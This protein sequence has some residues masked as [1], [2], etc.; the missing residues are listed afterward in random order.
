MMNPSASTVAEVAAIERSPTSLKR[1]LQQSKLRKRLAAMALIAP[2]AIFLLITFVLPIVILLQRAIENPEIATAL[3][4][5]V[6]ALDNW[7][8]KAA[9][10]DAA[11]AALAGDLVRAKADGTLGALARR[12]N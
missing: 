8:R 6:S 10:P 3:P 12:M 5:T 4:N 7:D 9:P 2:L 11:Y 1:E